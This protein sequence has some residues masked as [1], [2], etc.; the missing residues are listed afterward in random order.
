MSMRLVNGKLELVNKNHFEQPKQAPNVLQ[1]RPNVLQPRPNVLQPRANVQRPNVLQPRANVQRPNVEQI[2][3]E[4]EQIPMSE[5]Q[6]RQYTKR[7]KIMQY[8]KQQKEIQRIQQIKSKKLFF[9]GNASFSSS[10]SM[11]QFNQ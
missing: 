7:V 6:M 3:E 5:I 10:L 1:P 4:R 9:S 8:L 11:K 2:P